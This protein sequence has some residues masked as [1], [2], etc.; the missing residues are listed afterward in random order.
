[1]PKVITRLDTFRFGCG[2]F[3]PEMLRIQGLGSSQ[4]NTNKQIIVT[5]VCK[6][7]GPLMFA[8]NAIKAVRST[9]NY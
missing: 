7:Q 9:T 2:V 1:M 8:Q 5:G 3:G 6:W 4:A